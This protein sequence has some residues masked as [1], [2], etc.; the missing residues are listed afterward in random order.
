MTAA[1]AI[2]RITHIRHRCADSSRSMHIR[3][4]S[5]TLFD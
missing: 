2:D 3:A 5:R 1:E 4:R